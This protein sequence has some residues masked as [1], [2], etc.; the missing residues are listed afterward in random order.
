M[1]STFYVLSHFIVEILS[2]VDINNTGKHFFP[3]NS[4]SKD[5]ADGKCQRAYNL[6]TGATLH[7]ALDDH[8]LQFTIQQLQ[9]QKRQSR[10]LLDHSRSR[11][12]VSV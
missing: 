6:A 9:K 10:K 4:H 11:H 12:Q 8:Q 3:L 1:T 7:P 5:D 2:S